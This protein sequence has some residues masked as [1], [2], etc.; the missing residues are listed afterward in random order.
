[1]SPKDKLV[2]ETPMAILFW[3]TVEG[4]THYQLQVATDT[5]FT[6]IILDSGNIA[7]SQ[8]QLDLTE[9]GTYYWRVRGLN[10]WGPSPY[11]TPFA[12]TYQVIVATQPVGP[13][14][15]QQFKVLSSKGQSSQ[16]FSLGVPSAER[17]KLTFIN[18]ALG[19]QYLVLNRSLSPGW[20]S[21]A[22][23]SEITQSGVL[24]YQISTE[25]QNLTG[26]IIKLN[27]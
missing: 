12:L 6:E 25:H 22:Y 4:V 17:V 13:V 3:L 7:S 8:F 10:E 2:Q 1:V 15:P 23:P 9:M 14:V 5:A 19:T 18:P 11:S 26:R 27:P 24:I 16:Y 21:I 20:H